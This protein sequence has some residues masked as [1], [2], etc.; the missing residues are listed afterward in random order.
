VRDAEGTIRLARDFTTP[1]ELCSLRAITQDGKPHFD[2]DLKQ[3]RPVAETLAWIRAH[4]IRV[5]NVAGN[6]EHPR[7]PGVFKAACL[8]LRDIFVALGYER[9]P[10]A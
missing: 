4:N 3:P 1:G 2:I 8:Y 10:R 9:V 6:R 5:L 7:T